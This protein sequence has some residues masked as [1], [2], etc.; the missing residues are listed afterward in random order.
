MKIQDHFPQNK[1][2]PICGTN[3]DKKCGFIAVDGKLKGV[4]PDVQP[5]HLDCIDLVWTKKFYKGLD[6]IIMPFDDKGKKEIDQR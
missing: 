1:T 2:C 6:V 3:K 4:A 5:F